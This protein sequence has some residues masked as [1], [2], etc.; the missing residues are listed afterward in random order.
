MGILAKLKSVL[1]MDQEPVVEPDVTVEREPSETEPTDAESTDAEST[2]AESTDAEP[3]DAGDE[4]AGTA[5]Q[6]GAAAES[7]QTIKGV[8][9]AY[10]DQLGEAGVETVGDL[11]DADA[12]ALAE[13]SGLSPARI[14]NW[15]EQARART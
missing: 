12:E 13:A 9:P 10:A 15:V 7:V 4:P 11:A 14:E 3:A 1:G 2:D 6:T 5:E 8:G